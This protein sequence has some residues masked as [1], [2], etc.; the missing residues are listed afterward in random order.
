MA[1]RS[2]Q[3]SIIG[4]WIFFRGRE[5]SGPNIQIEKDR[6]LVRPLHLQGPT[7]NSAATNFRLRRRS[8]RGFC[9]RR[10]RHWCRHREIL[11]FHRVNQ[12]TVG[13]TADRRAIVDARCG[14]L[15]CQFRLRPCGRGDQKNC[16][17]EVFHQVFLVQSDFSRNARRSTSIEPD[18]RR[19]VQQSCRHRARPNSGLPLVMTP[20]AL[21]RQ[22][23]A[24]P[25]FPILSFD[26][27]R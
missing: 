13:R 2:L 11:A 15:G 14:A 1:F 18:Q 24:A 21:P 19:E 17:D 7:K 27:L 22:G 12:F 9:L 10:R 8:W 26:K 23:Q 20:A 6:L 25:I 4:T 5:I 3:Q 16:K